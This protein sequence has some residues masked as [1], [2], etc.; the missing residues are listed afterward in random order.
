MKE[1]QLNLNS[2]NATRWKN[3]PWGEGP[4]RSGGNPSAHNTVSHNAM[5]LI[6]INK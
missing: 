3:P 5:Q 4:G 1:P 6:K 2:G